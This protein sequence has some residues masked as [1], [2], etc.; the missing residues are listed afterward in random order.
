M[1]KKKL[2]LIVEWQLN[3]YG[4]QGLDIENHHLANTIVMTAI[5]GCWHQWG[6]HTDTR[7]WT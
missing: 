2:F 1:E 3:K 4:R 7:M 5:S 6:K